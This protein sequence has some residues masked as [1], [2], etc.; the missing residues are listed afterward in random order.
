M[1][2][3]SSPSISTTLGEPRGYC[4][5]EEGRG[6]RAFNSWT[7]RDQ[8]LAC[9]LQRSGLPTLSAWIPPSQFQVRP[10]GRLST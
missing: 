8:H 6:H 5:G 3:S 10:T 4:G 2:G 9:S 7:R 1:L